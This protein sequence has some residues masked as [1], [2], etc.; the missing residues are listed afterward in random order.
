MK[1]EPPLW[2]LFKNK[3]FDSI[4]KKDTPEMVKGIV[5]ETFGNEQIIYIDGSVGKQELD[6][7]VYSMK[8]NTCMGCQKEH[9]TTLRK[10]DG[11]EIS[12]TK[13]RSYHSK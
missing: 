4:T 6:V 7:H 12:S 3:I 9:P 1:S 2:I 10:N 8:I 11:G 13:P 5:L